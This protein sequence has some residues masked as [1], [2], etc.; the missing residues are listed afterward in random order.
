MGDYPSGL[1]AMGNRILPYG[2][3][4]SM[5]GGVMSAQKDLDKWY[6]EYQGKMRA[7]QEKVLAGPY[8]WCRDPEKCCKSG[9]CPRDPN[10][11][12]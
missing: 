11:G 10:C 1:W 12:E 7:Y 8:P 5:V 4:S 6:A 9:Y 2:G 3:H